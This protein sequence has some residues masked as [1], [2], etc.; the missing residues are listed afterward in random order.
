M[1][2]FVGCDYVNAAF[3]GYRDAFREV[4]K[5]EQRIRFFFSDVRITNQSIM[6]KVRDDIVERCDLGLYDVTRR[7]P[8][9]MMELGIA[10]GAKKH[11][12]ILYNPDQDQSQERRGWFARPTQN[13]QLPA[14]LRGVEYLEYRNRSQLQDRLAEWARQ[15]L[16]RNTDLSQRWTNTAGGVLSL[17]EERGE[18]TMNEIAKLTEAEVPMVK[19]T[20]GELRKKGLIDINGKR[21]P[22]ARYFANTAR[23][24]AA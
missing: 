11:W 3:H 4:Q 7:N 14:N 24:R 2:V 22:G 13:E 5:A 10:I 17:L 15:T 21:G 19:F 12:N 8:N 18:L 9:V 23:E 6:Q 20:V 16:E 1:L